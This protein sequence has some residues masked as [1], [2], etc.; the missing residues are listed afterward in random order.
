MHHLA[1]AGRTLLVE[2]PAGP[3]QSREWQ[4]AA[5]V[6]ALHQA[7]KDLQ[8]WQQLKGRKLQ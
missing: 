2:A 6:A 1:L 8:E 7:A 5:A 3:R 4:Q